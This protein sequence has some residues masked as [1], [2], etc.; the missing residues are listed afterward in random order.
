M[1][2]YMFVLMMVLVGCNEQS[3]DCR[4][5][6]CEVEVDFQVSQVI[7]ESGEYSSPA[8]N[9]YQLDGWVSVDC[10]YPSTTWPTDTEVTLY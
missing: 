8:S 10:G 2:K 1:K 7:C 3:Y 9:W 5:G 4:S 6:I